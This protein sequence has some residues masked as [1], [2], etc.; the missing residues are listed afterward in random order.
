MSTLPV[1]PGD[2]LDARK[3]LVLLDGKDAPQ[4]VRTRVAKVEPVLAG[5][6]QAEP[7]PERCFRRLV[8]DG[9][10]REATRFLAAALHRRVQV[11]WGYVCVQ[12]VFAHASAHRAALAAKGD[13]IAAALA[14]TAPGPRLAGGAA[15]APAGPP[16]PVMGVS[17]DLG[18]DPESFRYKLPVENGVDLADPSVWPKPHIAADGSLKFLPEGLEP[19]RQDPRRRPDA[20][21]RFFARRQAFIDRLSPA[22]RAEFLAE[23]A[24]SA[25]VV[26]RLVGRPLSAVMASD[27]ERALR[28]SGAGLDQ[29]PLAA[30]NQ[31]RNAL[32]AKKA[33]V[34]A[35]IGGW[36]DKLQVAMATLPQRQPVALGGD[37][38]EGGEAL[39]AARTW[40]LNPCRENGLAAMAAGE[41]CQGLDQAAGF[42][43][44]ACHFSGTDLNPAGT[45]RDVPPVTPP[46]SLAP[47]LVFAALELARSLPDSGRTPEEWS[48]HFLLYGRTVAQG[49]YTW[50]DL[51]QDRRDG[52]HP[53]WAGRA[54]FG[55]HHARPDE[56]KD[57]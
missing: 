15:A 3:P 13:G 8:L 35:A 25:A 43:A 45:P 9:H 29:D 48:D 22:A 56:R 39:R 46:P 52:R 36:M 16:P 49:L 34:Q 7:D 32:T 51:L 53:T 11:W 10:Q 37:S 57:G 6:A 12:A 54:G 27:R 17:H 33:E 24:T 5:T 44:M 50:D 28:A 2:P 26:E 4:I 18:V 21:D 42:I 47:N 23:D 1:W 30:H 20:C 40:I 55:R 41:R 38:P 31:L 19:L 14:A